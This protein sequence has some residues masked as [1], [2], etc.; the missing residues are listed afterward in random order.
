VFTDR[1]RGEGRS[2]RGARARPTGRVAVVALLVAVATASFAFAA[3]P[4]RS[5]SVVRGSAQ[6]SADTFSLTMKAANANIGLSYGRSFARYQDRTGSAEARALDLG[7]LPALFGGP[8]C[9]GSTPLL[10]AAALPPVTSADS[11]LPGAEQSRRTQ[12]FQPGIAGEPNGGPVGFQDATA[13]P[14]PS[15]EA[16]T[17]SVPADVFLVALIGGR[18]ETSASLRDG[19]REARAVVTADELRVLGGLF[20]LRQP[21]WEAVARSGAEE[22]TSSTFTFTSATV[23]GQERPAGQAF[24]DLRGFSAELGRLLAPFGVTLRL[25]TTQ[26]VEGG[27]RITPMGFVVQEPP[28]GTDVLVPFLGRIDPLVQALRQELVA[29]DCKNDVVLTVVDILLGVLGGSGSIE[30]LAGGVEAVTDDTDFAAPSPLPEPTEPPAEVAPETTIATD[31]SIDTFDPGFDV[32]SFDTV[33][34]LDLGVGELGLGDVDLASTEV[35]EQVR[36]ER[37]EEAAPLPSTIGSRFEEGSAGRAGVA[38][39]TVA[40]LGALGL[41]LG[42]RLVGRRSRRVIP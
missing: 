28:I 31:P 32:G 2:P 21:R 37:A 12:V 40:L 8:Q 7:A 24:A 5:D 38:V 30:I 36:A 1:F 34:P 4:A 3:A 33:P 41:S 11:T 42:D 23:L 25:P 14:L 18:T 17:E 9:D 16:R 27:V 15:S 6:A 29:Q 26:V 35:A 19:V 13:T 10:P 20:T 22:S 39:G